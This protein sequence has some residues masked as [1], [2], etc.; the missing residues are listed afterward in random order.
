LALEGPFDLGGVPLDAEAVG[1]GR[2]Q[3]PLHKGS[4]QQEPSRHE[5]PSPQRRCA[6]PRPHA[7]SKHRSSSLHRSS[8]PSYPPIGR[9]YQP[10]SRRLVPVVSSR[11]FIY[12]LD[13]KSP[14]DIKRPLD[15]EGPYEAQLGPN[16]NSLSLSLS[17]FLALTHS[18]THTHTH[19]LSLSLTH[20]H[21]TNRVR[22][23]WC[24]W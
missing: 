12:V 8:P 9:P 16:I 21:T 13:L 19:S 5:E 24:R 7:W 6:D 18:L 20:T 11:P 4:R 1:A 23:G 2:Q 3:P 17:L 22:G 10:R 14:L 15:N